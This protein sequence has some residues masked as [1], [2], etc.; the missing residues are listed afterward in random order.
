MVLVF[1]VIT[2][3]LFATEEVTVAEP[4]QRVSYSRICIHLGGLTK[5]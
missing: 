2:A 4:V 3:I 1:I 5:T